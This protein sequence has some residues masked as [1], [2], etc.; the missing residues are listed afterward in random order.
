MATLRWCRRQKRGIELIEPNENICQAYLKDADESI[1][2]LG[3]NAGKWQVV[4][5]Y[6]ASYN[7]L[8]AV[9]A[10]AG[11]KSEIHDCTLALMPLLGFTVEEVAFLQKLKKDRID[12]QYY[13]KPASLPDSLAVK[14]FV[15]RC[16]NLV[17][18]FHPDQVQR[19]RDLVKNA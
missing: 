14:R 17:Q 18:Q 15:V 11:I 12:A 4:M 10:K 5:A 13:L 16:K 9:A 2:T 7:A 1:L 3:K 8:Y 19:I 6:Y